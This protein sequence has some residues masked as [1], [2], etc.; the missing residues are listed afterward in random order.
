MSATVDAD[1]ERV[2]ALMMD[3]IDFASSARL[4]GDRP[5]GAIAVVGD[6][7]IGRG[8]ETC[9]RRDPTAH[10]VALV[11]TDAGR[12][13]GSWRLDGVTVVATHEPCPMCAGALNAAKVARLVFGASDPARGAAG[14]RYNVPADRRLGHEVEVVPG[15]LA[16]Q[17][18][19]L[20][21]DD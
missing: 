3:A 5:R 4:G 13:I 9:S 7:V 15:V 2:V 11:L 12:H 21:R 20:D 16:E 14:S 8:D 10:A 19:A 1:A 6:V 18:A 17:C